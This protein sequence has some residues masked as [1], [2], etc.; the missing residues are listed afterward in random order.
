[1]TL[2]D[3]LLS[4]EKRAAVVQDCTQ[5]IHREVQRRKGVSGFAIKSGFKVVSKLDGGQMVPKAVNDLLPDFAT[6]IEPF[7]ADFRAG[8]SE[9]FH[10]FATG[11]EVEFADALLGITDEKAQHAK[12]NVLKK[13]YAKLRPTAQRQ[14]ADS[15]PAVAGLIDRHHPKG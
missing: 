11:R 12:N 10:A 8:K 9:S 14:L 6:A 2:P 13:L 1:M 4:E 5:L 7:H 15:I 3:V